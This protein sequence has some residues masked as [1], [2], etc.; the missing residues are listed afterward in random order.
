MS[1][2]LEKFRDLTLFTL[3]T[4]SAAWGIEERSDA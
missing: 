4:F 3:I 2:G 1:E